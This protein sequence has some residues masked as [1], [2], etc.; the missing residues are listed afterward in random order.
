MAKHEPGAMWAVKP[1]GK[2]PQAYVK[3]FN[4]AELHIQILVS[5]TSGTS[6][7]LDRQM[8]RMLAKRIN[9]CLDDTTSRA[10]RVK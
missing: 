10:R 4:K 6:F 8:A 9:Q 1:I 5:S 7:V 2:Y 3:T